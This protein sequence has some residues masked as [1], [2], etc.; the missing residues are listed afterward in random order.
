[1][2]EEWRDIKGYEG[3]YQVSNLGKVKSLDKYVAHSRNKN[4]R[5]SFRKGKIISCNDNGR[6]YL[7]VHLYKDGKKNRKVKYIHRVVA[8]AFLENPNAY[9]FVNHKDLDKSNNSVCNL[10]WCSHL[11][12]VHHA[13]RNGRTVLNKRRI[14]VDLY[15]DGEFICWFNSVFA[16]SMYVGR[17]IK[18][19]IPD[20][21][22]KV[23][24]YILYPSKI[25]PSPSNC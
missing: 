10:E 2:H 9:R 20:T 4:Y 17:E 22:K 3:H 23:G 18:T 15:K 24:G 13:I 5:T 19:R 14:A 25:G 1:M 11:Q 16:A 12:N 21:G 6:G 7:Q 8:E